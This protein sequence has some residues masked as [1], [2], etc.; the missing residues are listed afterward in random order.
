[1]G[2]VEVPAY[3]KHGVMQSD[4]QLSQPVSRVLTLLVDLQVLLWNRIP[5]ASVGS[6]LMH[7][8]VLTRQRQADPSLPPVGET[9]LPPFTDQALDPPTRLSGLGAQRQQ[10]LS[11]EAVEQLVAGGAVLTQNQ[12]RRGSA[13]CVPKEFFLVGWETNAAELTCGEM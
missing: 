12:D 10:P 7:Q 5:A 11:Q 9:Q 2:S 8:L 4:F 3:L 6:Q 13:D 1:M